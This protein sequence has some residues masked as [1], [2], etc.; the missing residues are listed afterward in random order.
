VTFTLNQVYGGQEKYVL[1]EAEV[2]PA[3]PGASMPLATVS[4]TYLDLI[5]GRSE[6]ERKMVSVRFSDSPMEV[7]AAQTPGV[8]VA[9]AEAIANER[10]RLALDLRDRGEL[11]EAQ[12]VLE[13]NSDYLNT[14]AARYNAPKLRKQAAD[15]VSDANNLEGERWN[16]QRKVMRK[17]QYELDVQQSF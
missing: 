12:V 10:N 14:A 9:H 4:A 1:L 15:N 2:V 5:S 8:M 17:R 11:R 7:D 6:N 16:K 13:N 3:Y